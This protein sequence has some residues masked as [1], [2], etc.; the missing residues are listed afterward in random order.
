MFEQKIDKRPGFR[1]IATRRRNRLF[2]E[3]N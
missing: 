1:W 2:F 3:H